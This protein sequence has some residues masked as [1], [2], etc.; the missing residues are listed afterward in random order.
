MLPTYTH[1]DNSLVGNVSRNGDTVIVSF[2]GVRNGDCKKHDQDVFS[3]PHGDDGGYTKDIAALREILH[4]SPEMNVA[5]IYSSFGKRVQ[6]FFPSL[7]EAI[8]KQGDYGEIVF[9]GVGTGGALAA[10]ATLKYFVQVSP[11]P[12]I[13]KVIEGASIRIRHHIKVFQ[14]E[15]QAVL[16][17]AGGVRYKDAI[18]AVGLRRPCHVGYN[19]GFD[20]VAGGCFFMAAFEFYMGHYSEHLQW[21]S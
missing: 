14:F 18:A 19:N 6:H 13:S 3:D 16:N 2:H 20:W 5:S 11:P 15:P 8:E 17:F 7:K 1:N 9:T 4:V 10:L 21:S 12:A